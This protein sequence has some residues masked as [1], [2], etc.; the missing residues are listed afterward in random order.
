VQ[1][2]A[3]CA[4]INFCDEASPEIMQPYLEPLLSKLANLLQMVQPQLML[5]I[6]VFC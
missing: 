3:A 4:V 1:A 2:H 5:A 6:C